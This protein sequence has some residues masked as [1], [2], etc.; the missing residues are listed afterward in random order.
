MKTK[1]HID[2]FKDMIT[3]SE[4]LDM[5]KNQ[6]SKYT[7]YRWVQRE[8]MPHQKIKGTKL[9][10]LGLYDR[11]IH[12]GDVEKV[13]LNLSIRA[14]GFNFDVGTGGLHGSVS[15]ATVVSDELGTIYDWDVASFYPN[16]S[17][18]NNLKPEHFSQEFCLIFL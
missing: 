10:E 9:V 15:A 5:L 16:I 7:I 13:A 2:Y 18:Q 17:I 12:D 4:L 14:D 1:I 3:M 11:F 6:Y 8:G